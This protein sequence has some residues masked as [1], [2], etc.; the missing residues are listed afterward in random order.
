MNNKNIFFNNY[1]VI[2]FS[3][4]SYKL[5]LFIYKYLFIYINPLYSSLHLSYF[6][7][8]ESCFTSIIISTFYIS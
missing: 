5:Y 2:K 6:I 3:Y 1:V 4:N 8:L 7:L